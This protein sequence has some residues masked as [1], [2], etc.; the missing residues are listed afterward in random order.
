MSHSFPIVDSKTLGYDILQVNS[1]IEVARNQYADSTVQIVS[2]NSLRNTEFDLVKGG[3]EILSVDIAM[4]RL[5][6]AFAK[7]EIE[8]QRKIGGEPAVLDLLDRVR[9]IVN[10]RL[11]RPKN[12]KFTRVGWLLRGYD[13]SEVDKLC[14]SISAH[15][16]SGE[17]LHLNSVRKSIFKSKRNGY[18]EAQ[19]DAFLD[20]AVE[21]L[22]IEK[23]S[24]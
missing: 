24:R 16:N 12:K 4:D 11:V 23:N 19:V 6:D 7:R 3:Y 21:I 10:G 14:S 15:L 8:R 2:S 1:F 5:E 20:R 13:R 22:Q 9:D 17:K 18:L